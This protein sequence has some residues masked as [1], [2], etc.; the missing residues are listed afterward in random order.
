M[1]PIIAR[2]ITILQDKVK[3][4]D[5]DFS[6]PS[7]RCTV[8]YACIFQQLLVSDGKIT[9]MSYNTETFIPKQSRRH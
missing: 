5:L 1:C 6:S 8:S 3:Q 7:W 9:L 4:N 2:M